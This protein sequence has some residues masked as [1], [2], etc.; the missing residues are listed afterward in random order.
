MLHLTKEK[1]K[2]LQEYQQAWDSVRP[3][4]GKLKN[5]QIEAYQ[6]AAVNPNRITKTLKALKHLPHKAQAEILFYVENRLS[7]LKNVYVFVCG[8]RFGKSFIMADMA[9]AEA[10]LPNSATVLWTPSTKNATAIFKAVDANVKQ[11]HQLG[12]E[13]DPASIPR[14]GKIPSPYSEYSKQNLSFTVRDTNATFAVVTNQN[15]Q[16]VLGSR[17]SLFIAD[18]TSDITDLISRYTSDIEPAMADYG[19]LDEEKGITFATA[20]FIG[21]PR[22]EGTEFHDLFIRCPIQY[23]KHL[24]TAPPE[25]YPYS[26]WA[27]VTYPTESNPLVSSVYLE[28]KRKTTPPN[29]FANEY[30]AKFLKLSENTVFDCFTKDNIIRDSEVIELCQSS[31]NIDFI[32]GID[33]GWSD[34]NSYI[35]LA[36]L[37]DRLVVVDCYLKSQEVTDTHIKN[38]LGI[39]DNWGIHEGNITRYGDRAAPQLIADMTSKGFTVYSGNSSF[40]PS[41]KLIN[42][43]FFN[44]LL[45]VNEKCTELIRQLSK[46]RLKLN[47]LIRKETNIADPYEPDKEKKTHWDLISALRYAVFSYHSESPL[48]FYHNKVDLDNIN[49]YKNELEEE[50]V[51]EETT[52]VFNPLN[53]EYASPSKVLPKSYTKKGKQ[54]LI[55]SIGERRRRGN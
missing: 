2:A 40:T 29:T 34:S 55:S 33:L 42:S 20:F 21:T 53:P 31:N 11:L 43:L 25:S 10:M 30:L 54:H 3:V 26:T 5:P 46:C 47:Y 49:A 48:N 14:G 37:K 23:E 4:D 8:R 32:A 28:Q 17:I 15:V 52:T 41:L 24:L 39:E 13:A 50:E 44:G 7:L 18:E 6:R 45:F 38:Y 22:Y 9:T 12:Y 1:Q 36:V 51:V 35:V 27:S 16:N 19:M